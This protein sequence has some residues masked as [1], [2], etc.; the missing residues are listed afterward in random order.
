MFQYAYFMIICITCRYSTCFRFPAVSVC[1]PSKKA[2][3]N[4]L[5]ALQLFSERYFNFIAGSSTFLVLFYSLIRYSGCPPRLRNWDLID[6]NC[7]NFLIF[8]DFNLA[9]ESGHIKLG[10]THI[11]FYIKLEEK[12]FI[13][14]P[15]TVKECGN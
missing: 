11:S 13:R 7:D 9:K 12:C 14:F 4:V 8:C 5:D 15:N 6:R 3:F 10:H 2:V 1:P